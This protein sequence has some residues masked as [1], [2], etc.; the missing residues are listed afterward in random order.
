MHFFR[1]SRSLRRCCPSSSAA[2]PP[3][4][5]LTL[6]ILRLRSPRPHSRQR[7]ATPPVLQFRLLGG[8]RLRCRSF[9][10]RRGPSRLGSPAMM[11]WALVRSSP[12]HS[13]QVKLG[14]PPPCARRTNS[15][16]NSR[17]QTS[18]RA[19]SW[20]LGCSSTRAA[21]NP[22]ARFHAHRQSRRTLLLSISQ[23]YRP[24]RPGRS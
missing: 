24:A 8:R 9:T 5:L 6:Q 15:S 1:G 21:Q 10:S 20:F 16:A 18:P 23:S 13:R 3:R 7:P 11:R 14:L 12:S 4:A 17:W 19:Q 22:A 2:V